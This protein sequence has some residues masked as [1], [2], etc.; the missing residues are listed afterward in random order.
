MYTDS[1][2]CYELYT[3]NEK[4]WFMASC[5]FICLPF[6]LIWNASLRFIQQYIEHFV[7]KLGQ[8][9]NSKYIKGLINI[10]LVLYMFPPIGTLLIVI[11]E[12]Y[13]IMMEIHNGIKAFIL[14][15]GLVDAADRQTKAM[16]KL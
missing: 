1:V 3:G 13:G 6:M 16:K 9:R 8:N 11:Y 5:L 15:T 4:V 2:I 12:I 7:S 10:C 14:G